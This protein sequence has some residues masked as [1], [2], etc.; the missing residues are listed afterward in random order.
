[1]P[2]SR[3]APRVAA[4]VAAL[5]ALALAAAFT[6]ADAANLT[7][8]NLGAAASLADPDLFLV[9]PNASGGPLESIRWSVLR[10]QIAAGLGSTWLLPANNL[11][12]LTNV[13]AARS[14]LGLGTAA[15]ANTGNSGA[16]VPLLSAAN[17]WSGLQLVS[18]IAAGA[19]AES[20]IIQNGA[21]DAAGDE[22]GLDLQPSPTGCR[23]F[24]SGYRDGSA[25]N[26][27][28]HLWSCSSNSRNV[29]VQ[30]NGAGQTS[31]NQRASFLSALNIG[32]RQSVTIVSNNIAA[33]APFIALAPNSGNTDSLKTI[34][35]GQ[36]GDVIV[37]TA[38]SGNSV[39]IDNALSTTG[40]NIYIGV[41]GANLLLN[42]SGD[43]MMLMAWNGIWIMLSYENNS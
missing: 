28:I 17:T 19:I 1:M 4:H 37:L 34:A 41:G 16:T 29:A 27:G 30:V 20:A 15:T 3:L 5:G 32:P 43:T 9:W 14:N 39:T 11:S 21:A 12:E 26:T 10:A 25:V 35:A 6:G 13:A 31:F 22:A 38:Q 40:G 7:P 23:A 24:V 2:A 18:T 42:S 36:D 8:P 33:T